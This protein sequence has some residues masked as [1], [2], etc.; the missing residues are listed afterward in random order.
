MRILVLGNGFDLDLG[1]KTT[2]K[3]FFQNVYSEKHHLLSDSLEE[4]LT[5]RCKSEQ[6]WFNIEEAMAMYV[7][8]KECPVNSTIL[9]MDKFF[10]H[11]LKENFSDYIDR[12]WATIATNQ[13]NKPIKQ[14]LAK[15]I[16]ELQNEIHCFDK[17]YSF[18]C[19]NYS[20]L[21][22][23]SDLEICSIPN[24]IYLHGSSD[25][26]ILGIIESDCKCSDY[27]FMIKKNQ[28]NYPKEKVENFKHDLIKA[29]EVVIFG[30]SLNRIDMEY[31]NYFFLDLANA[32]RNPRKITII[33]KDMNSVLEIKNNISDYVISFEKANQYSTISFVMSDDYYKK[34]NIDEA[35]CLFH[36]LTCSKIKNNITL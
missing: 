30:H 3:D 17:I 34:E 12:N 14:S 33:T 6:N 15:K 18:N 10:L 20:L 4:F 35:N 5:S 13:W 31:F 28:K 23:A 21:D 2:Y 11:N 9:D 1:L 25:S 7:R 27:S 26:F 8:K 19:F 24:V 16:I 22:L 32:S 36:R 29:D